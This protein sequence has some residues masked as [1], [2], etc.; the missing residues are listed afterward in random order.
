MDTPKDLSFDHKQNKN[1]T[2]TSKNVGTNLHDAIDKVAEKAK[3]AIDSLAQSAHKNVE[4]LAFRGG[5]LKTYVGVIWGQQKLYT[6]TPVNV[7]R[8]SFRH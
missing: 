4:R 3:P 1:V 5:Q 7:G 6:K 2:E 8:Y